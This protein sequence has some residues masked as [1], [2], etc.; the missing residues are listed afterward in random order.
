M[1]LLLLLFALGSTSCKVTKTET[2]CKGDPIKDC[3]TT[4]EYKPVC[5]CDGRSYSNAG[6]ARCA[7]LKT[8]TEGDCA[9]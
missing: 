3:I 9:K 1:K 5:G 2:L 8:W 6:M 7:G 4:M